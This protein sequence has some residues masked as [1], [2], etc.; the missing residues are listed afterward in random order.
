MF[1]DHV[2]IPGACLGQDGIIQDHGHRVSSNKRRFLVTARVDILLERVEKVVEGAPL[3]S[4]RPLLFLSGQRR[5]GC[6]VVMGIRHD[7]AALVVVS[8]RHKQRVEQLAPAVE[9]GRFFHYLLLFRYL[10]LLVGVPAEDEC[11]AIL[12]RNPCRVLAV[13]GGGPDTHDVGLVAVPCVDD[14][15]INEA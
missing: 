11:G 6:L 8:S 7:F 5:R 12:K 3:F 9:R 15:N 14:L 2:P 4:F 1:K 10:P 13:A